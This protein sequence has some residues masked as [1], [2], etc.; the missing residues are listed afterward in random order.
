MTLIPEA[1]LFI[2]GELRGASDGGTYDVIS[3]WTGQPVGKAAD[4]IL[5]DGDPSKDLG[6]L[7]HVRTVFL[8][9]YRLDAQA[10][11]QASGL[12]GMPN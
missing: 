6:A 12:S 9:G 3:P 2:D 5:V 7:R 8:E 1:K 4:V 11:R 10:L